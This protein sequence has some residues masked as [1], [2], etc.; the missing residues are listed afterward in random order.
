MNQSKLV[1]GFRGGMTDENDDFYSRRIMTDIF[2]GGPY[3][4]LL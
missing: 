4:R 3:S 1:L 2:G